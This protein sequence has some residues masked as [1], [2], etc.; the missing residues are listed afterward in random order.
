MSD[1]LTMEEIEATYDGEWVVLD[2]IESGPKREILRARVV[3]HGA[4]HDEAWARS[5]DTDSRHIAVFY[6]GPI[7]AEDE[8]VLVL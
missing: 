5:Y 3:W 7:R 1:L 2:Q 4:D 6:V 8:P